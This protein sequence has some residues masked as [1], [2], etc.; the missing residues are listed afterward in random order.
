MTEQDTT[1]FG[2]FGYLPYFKSFGMKKI[3]RTYKFISFQV[4]SMFILEI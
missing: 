1:A 4:H 3:E 2:L